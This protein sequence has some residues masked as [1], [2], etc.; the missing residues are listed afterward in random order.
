MVEDLPADFVERPNEFEELISKLLDDKREEPVAITA[1][2]RGA[3]GYGKT[4]MAKAICHD[5]RIQDAFDD[6]ILWVTLGESPGNLVGKV[7]DLIYILTKEK[8][9]LTGPDVA[10]ANL[11]ELLAARE[12]LLIVDDVWNAA[13]LKPFLQGGKR[14]ARLITTRNHHV[15]PPNAQP[16]Q[17]D[18]MRQQEAVQLLCKGLNG[19]I[20]APK[21]QAAFRALATQLGEW[22][23]LLTLVNG[24]LRKRVN[25]HHQCLPDALAYINKALEKRG[26]TAFDDKNAQDRTQAAAKTLSVSLE[27]LSKDEQARYKEL[28]IFP[29]DIDIPLATLQKLWGATGKLDDFDTE[30]L[31]E[32]LHDLSLLLRF[33]PTSRTLCLHDV[34][35]AYLQQEAKAELLMLHAQLL[36]AYQIK[37]WANLPQNEPY[38]WDHLV[39]H[40]IEA[41]R[42]EELLSTVK[43]LRY[44]SAKIHTRGIRAAE[45]DLVLCEKANLIDPALS[46]LR[47]KVASLDYIL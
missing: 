2:L 5:S 6:G 38:L 17:V 32:R 13:H 39:E 35:R 44:I 27:L 31:C 15:L 21:N 40:L 37:R 3:G 33:D 22:P 30:E 45:A 42:L 7:E 10:T 8:P 11:A 9:N 46:L 24:V 25:E 12:I 41:K 1:A 23:L 4:T 36:D 19:E 28:A 34:V 47:R 18:A 16:I 29:E 26:L 43:D 14:C 20:N